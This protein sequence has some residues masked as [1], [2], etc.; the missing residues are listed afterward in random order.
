LSSA[1]SSTLVAPLSSTSSRL[2]ALSEQAQQLTARVPHQSTLLLHR[3]VEQL[4]LAARA[5]AAKH[6]GSVDGTAGSSASDGG[7]LLLATHGVDRERLARAL[8]HIDLKASFEPLHAVQA[9][10]LDAYLRHAHDLAILAAV[11]EAKR[12]ASSHLRYASH[13]QMAADWAHCKLALCAAMTPAPVQ[14][15]APASNAAPLDA[16][17]SLLGALRNGTAAGAGAGAAPLSRAAMVYA[18]AVALHN[19]ARRERRNV[20]L[21][22]EL[23]GGGAA[24]V[25]LV[26]AL[27]AA[28]AAGETDD[29][30]RR[31]DCAE[32]FAIVR[33]LVGERDALAPAPR[34]YA[35]LHASGSER[36][37]RA[38][39][40]AAVAHLE[41][42]Y[43][44][45]ARIC[46]AE[47]AALAQVGSTPSA[48]DV[49][50]GLVRV[51][52]QRPQFPPASMARDAPD[53]D[54]EPFWPQLYYALRCGALDVALD[55]VQRKRMIAQ[56]DVV[57]CVQLRASRHALLA[58]ER[59]VAG[60]LPLGDL[61]PLDLRATVRQALS[62]RVHSE[63]LRLSSCPFR[64]AVLNLLGQCDAALIDGYVVSSAQDFLW[65]K[66]S[67]IDDSAGAGAGAQTAGAYHLAQ[68]QRT[69]LE[70]GGEHFGAGG[71]SPYLY[72]Q[73]L[74]LTQQF[75]RAITYLRSLPGFE[76][77]AV[78]FA[79]ALHHYGLLRA[80]SGGHADPRA[81][82]APV[83]SAE[84]ANAAQ[85]TFNFVRFVRDYAASFEDRAP[86]DALQYLYL[87]D[88][89]ERDSP[90]ELARHAAIAA[91][92]LRAHD[93]AELV[94]QTGADGERAPGLLDRFL[95]PKSVKHVAAL[96]AR[97]A[98]EQGRTFEALALYDVCGDAARLLQLLAAE[99]ARLLPTTGAERM[100]VFSWAWA[101]HT[102]YSKREYTN[103]DEHQ[104]AIAFE[105]MLRLVEFFELY[106]A[107]NWPDALRSV[108]Q[109][110]L[111]PLQMEF[112][113]EVRTLSS[114]SLSLSL[115]RFRSLSRQISHHSFAGRRAVSHAG[116][117][118]ARQ[119]WRLS[120]GDDAR[121]GR[122]VRAGQ[123][124]GAEWRRRRRVAARHAARGGARAGRL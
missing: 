43:A 51:L 116:Q 27:A 55:M 6:H 99:L 16:H 58:K 10:D 93:F 78:H 76:V 56:E 101:A 11:E 20:S 2:K 54:G 19:D 35:V 95:A 89:D 34:E 52:R 80:P 53:L 70:C 69:L 44:E 83:W 103:A 64:I 105:Q 57:Q 22:P 59:S 14:P 65:F 123:V 41:Q 61:Q 47:N 7:A 23:A 63:R 4:D 106:R 40:L 74:L 31:A 62:D 46:V 15:L 109:H 1:S 117:L 8:Q 24:R 77:D 119:L 107:A 100:Q 13:E 102:K 112:V 28:A 121:A 72:F 108:E 79:L 87:I 118:R 66:L 49:I 115:S 110:A 50:L 81:D 33:A 37:R 91:Q 3:S 114:L 84:A 71:R 88:D 113:A 45:F 5:L 12:H 85:A 25:P 75:E 60:V 122:A 9:H 73:L 18:D 30:Y 21:E 97:V 104:S 120:A 32:A 98:A 68:L 67:M 86:L 42:H 29:V 48:A 36:L 38:M 92:L 96:A 39:R 94:G 17:A 124:C 90:P 111:V 82:A 26:A